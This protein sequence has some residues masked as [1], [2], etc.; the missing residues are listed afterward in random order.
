M[1]GVCLGSLEERRMI[2]IAVIP[3]RRM[4]TALSA[5]RISTG[6]PF[7]RP[8]SSSTAL[9]MTSFFLLVSDHRTGSGP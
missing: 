3:F 9:G 4:I 7:S 2:S 1:M 8:L 5:A 6:S